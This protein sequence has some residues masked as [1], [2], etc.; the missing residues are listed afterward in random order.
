MTKRDFE[1][2]SDGLGIGLF[3]FGVFCAVLVVQAMFQGVEPEPTQFVKVLAAVWVN[4]IGAF[5]S[6]VLNG[7]LAA[8]GARIFLAGAVPNLVRHLVGLGFL[9]ASL[10]VLFGAFGGAAGGTFGARTGGA[11][12]GAT[13]VAL[14]ALIGALAATATVWFVWLRRDQLPAEE[15]MSVRNPERELETVDEDEG[16]STAEAEALLPVRPLAVAAPVRAA[17]P[18]SPYPEDVRRKG[19]IPAGTRPLSN[20]DAQTTPAAPAFAPTVYRWTAPGARRELEPASPTVAP[21]EHELAEDAL[22]ADRYTVA[23]VES[24]VQAA[25]ATDK[26]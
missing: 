20:P 19:E 8:I 10:S 14:G 24:D 15:P 18:P 22:D 4:S 21:V 2:K 3:A 6:L 7:A 11:L 12:S 1:M 17:P 5:P 13:H 26:A 25:R 23:E 16:V 9:S